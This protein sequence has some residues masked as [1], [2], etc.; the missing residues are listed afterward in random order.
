IGFYRVV[1]TGVSPFG[2]STNQALQGIVTIDFEVGS[3]ASFSNFSLYGGITNSAGQLDP[4][5]GLD[6]LT[7]TNGTLRATWDT[8]FMTNGTYKLV[9]G[10]NLGDD[11]IPTIEGRA[12]TA[13]LSNSIWF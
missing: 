13:T 8:R 3:V 11:N 12:F 10:A 2:W 1:R 4:I 7:L 5:Q 6:F 9:F